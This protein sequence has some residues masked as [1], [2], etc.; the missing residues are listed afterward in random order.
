MTQKWLATFMTPEFYFDWRRTG[1][2]NLGKNM[3]TGIKGDKI[4][5]R[6][7]YGTNEKI[8]NGENYAKGVTTLEPATDD[9][10]S[11]M[12]LLKGTGKPY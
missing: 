6:Y 5:L 8:L 4:P 2:P 7:I 3:I 12:W 10:W 1:T 11:K 9:Q